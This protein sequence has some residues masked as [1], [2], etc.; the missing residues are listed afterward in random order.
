[1]RSLQ[2]LWL[3]SSVP[4]GMSMSVLSRVHRFVFILASCPRPQVSSGFIQGS[5]HCIPLLLYRTITHLME[6][7]KEL[8]KS[9]T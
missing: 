1:M 4:P 7:L 2:G 8:L 6:H 5:L 3:E 9:I